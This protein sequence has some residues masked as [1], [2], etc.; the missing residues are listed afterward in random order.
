MPYEL[1]VANCWQAVFHTRHSRRLQ[2]VDEVALSV[3]GKI[4]KRQ[5][6]DDGPD[7]NYKK[8]CDGGNCRQLTFPP[9]YLHRCKMGGRYTQGYRLSSGKKV[10]EQTVKTPGKPCQMDI[11]YFE[12][13][14]P[15]A[16]TFDCKCENLR[17]IRYPCPINGIS[18]I[19]WDKRRKN[20][21]PSLYKSE[22]DPLFLS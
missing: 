6:A 15:V 8:K 18:H 1:F 12:R 3:N 2:N 20:H 9:F 22:A 21:G 16:T 19:V 13:G 11:S 5:K 7:T 14:R 10:T 17:C 4:V